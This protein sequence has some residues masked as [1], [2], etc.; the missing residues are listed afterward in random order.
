MIYRAPATQSPHAACSEAYTDRYGAWGELQRRAAEVLAGASVHDSY[1]LDPFPPFFEEGR[2][3]YK[4]ATGGRS[5]VDYWMGHGALLCGHS[6]PPVV[7][8][9]IE[10]ARRATHL[11][12]LCEI[13]V[14]WAELV[15][16][17]IPSAERIRFTASGTESTLLAHRVA[18]AFTGRSRVLKLAGHFHGWHDESLGHFFPTASSGFNPDA[19][20]QVDVLPL[21]DGE[22]A[23]ERLEAED[24]AGVILEPGGGGTGALPW[25]VELLRSLREATLRHGSLLL[26]D[27]T[28][29][30]FRYSPGG[31]QQLTGVLP[32]L[33]ILGKILA[34]G[35]PGGAV[36]GRA[37][38][39]AA[40]GAG[41][42]RDSRRIQVPHTGTFNANPLSAAAGVAMLSQLGD[43]AAQRIAIEATERLAA[44]VNQAA[45]A[46]DIDISLFCAGTSIFHVVIGARAAGLSAEP[47]AGLIPLFQREVERHAALRRAL[48]LEG[49]DCH[50]M[51]GWVSTAHDQ[52]AIAETV[53]AFTRAFRRLANETEFT[54]R[55]PVA[56]A[57]AAPEP[58]VSRKTVELFIDGEFRPG[59]AG[60]RFDSIEPAS[61]EVIADVAL[62][63][64][65]DVDLAVSAARRAFEAGPWPRMSAAERRSY[66]RAIGDAIEENTETLACL[67][68]MDTGL[69]IHF[70]RGHVARAVQNFRYFAEEAERIS[71][72]T[73]P[74]DNAYLHI[75][76]REPVGVVAVITPWN[77]PLGLAAHG[78]AAA[79][80]CGNTCV[81][82]PS[83]Y[84]PMTASELAR[85]FA[86]LEL[87]PG[88]LNVVQ[89][90]GMPT[91][92]ALVSH[93][94]VDA[95]AFTGSSAT[96]RRIME[97][98]ASG[99]KRF[100]AELGGSAPTLIF[101]DCD[102]DRAI[103]GTLLCAFAN[104]GEACVAGSRLLVERPLLP[105]FL[106][107]F[108]AR[109]QRIAV[110]DPLDERTEV[111]PLISRAHRDRVF[112]LVREALA[113]GARLSCGGL[114]SP[115]PVGFFAQPTVVTDVP[116][117]ARLVSEEV[118]GPVVT[119]SAFDAEAEVVKYANASPYG[120]AAYV[121]TQN[122]ERM[123]RVAQRLRSGTVWANTSL[124][125]D[126]R[127]PFGGYKQSGVGRVGGGFSIDAFTEVKNTCVTIEPLQLPRLGSR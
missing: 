98:A 40:F 1:R 13:M 99:L 104:N 115:F 112:G 75:V 41:S 51:H 20:H 77:A 122:P 57:V 35:L 85:I 21:T 108:T 56:V 27:E 14:R 102:L 53:D 36:V 31:V 81:L 100:V 42:E 46:C 67:E 123:F 8:A 79:L 87:P 119:V 116:P 24:I 6:F 101:A 118:L 125:R 84:A 29:S 110:G 39:M 5:F 91:G 69:P 48:L 70:T 107:R 127:V 62:A 4:K 126:I 61:E 114:A 19:L 94:G 38:V 86:E 83:E 68:T 2:G 12:G 25:G 105:E 93:P 120:L 10:Q 73:H 15:R 111:G 43:G 106:E 44:G 60:R 74:L 113:E 76:T 65:G 59:V 16:R 32:D 23:L 89:G 109:V 7:E 124:V 90:P 11:G 82:K 66:L 17:L 72:T 18:R 88:V 55:R 58:A 3:A 71:G 9:V 121:W 37:E 117:S 45:L 80:T 52:P 78:V 30:G 22:L 63:E 49:V 96:G 47:S 54:A 92:D 95:I 26:F 103:E 34:G 97:S 28:V 33:T 50:P 64:A